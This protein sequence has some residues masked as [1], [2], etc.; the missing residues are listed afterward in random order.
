VSPKGGVGKTTVALNLGTALACQQISVVL[1]D[2]TVTGDLDGA[3]ADRPGGRPG[4]GDLLLGKATLDQ[5]LLPTAIPDLSLV[6][7]GSAEV[8]DSTLTYSDQRQW[9]RVLGTIS[10]RAGVVIV[11]TPAGMAGV[12]QNIVASASHLLGVLQAEY[13]AQ[14]AFSLFTRSLDRIAGAHR[15]A[16]LGIVI[17]MLQA[18]CS[19]SLAVL[20]K[21]SSHFPRGW[22]FLTTLPRSATVL[23]ASRAGVPL[24]LLDRSRPPPVAWLFDALAAEV[25]ERLN[26]GLP[27]DGDPIKLLPS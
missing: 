22:P 6:P 15:P 10:E 18:D 24:R 3:L 27:R 17:N 19:T 23:D 2:G 9:R 20:A 13:L 26:I 12:T 16:V 14:R 21:A 7:A 5:V 8:M 11:D 1:V 25:A 4:L